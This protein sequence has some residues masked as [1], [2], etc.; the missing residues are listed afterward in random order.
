MRWQ[1][2]LRPARPIIWCLLCLPWVR[3]R[4]SRCLRPT[5]VG[6]DSGHRSTWGRHVGVTGARAHRGQGLVAGRRRR[7]RRDIWQASCA[8]LDVAGS[9]RT[10]PMGSEPS[11]GP[12]SLAARLNG[13]VRGDLRHLVVCLVAL[14]ASASADGMRADVESHSTSCTVVR[15]TREA[16]TTSTWRW[17]PRSQDARSWKQ[18]CSAS[19]T[20][21]RGS[22]HG[23]CGV[24]SRCL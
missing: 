20:Q 16:T 22:C 4:L 5:A 12:I 15:D 18:W 23:V 6:V 3:L 2:W 8:R 14:R 9:A 24:A 10:C 11:L 7:K 19:V 21:P 13:R 17:C 1:P